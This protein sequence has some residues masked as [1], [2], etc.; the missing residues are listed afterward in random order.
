MKKLFPILLTLAS[1]IVFFACTKVQ[2]LPYYPE[3]TAVTLTANK[4][5]VTATAADSNNNVLTFNWS[6]PKYSSDSSTWKY[7]LEIDSTGKNFANKTTRTFTGTSSGSLT[8]KDLNDIMLNYGYSIGSAVGMDFRVV[9]SYGNNNERYVSNTVKVLV[10]P[11]NDPAVLTSEK[12]SVTGTLATAGNPS[13]TFSW[14]TAFRG[15]TGTVTYSLQY[16]SATKNFASP[17]EMAVGASIYSKTLT[18]AEMNQAALNEG[19]AGGT[20]GKIEFRIKAT[21]AQGAVSYSA[22]VSVTIGAYVPAYNFYLVGDFNGWDINTAPELIS[23]RAG[24]RW[25]KVF[26]SYVYMTAGQKF[27]FVKTRGDWGSKYGYTGGGA[28]GIY[29]IGAMG[30]GSDFQV[31]TTGVYRI[32]IDFNAN[33]AYVQ[34]KQVGVVGGMQGWNPGS[35][36]YGGLLAKDKFLIIAPSSGSDNFK[37]H[38][39]PVWD[40]SAPDKAR[41]WGRGASAGLLDNDGNGPD[42]TASF[43]PYTRAIWDGTDP[44]QLKYSLSNGQLRVV[45]GAASLG[46]WDPSAAPNMN[47]MGNGVWQATITLTGNTEF[48]FVSAEGWSY[49]YGGSG[50]SGNAGTI[51]LNGPNLNKPAGTYT[52]TVNE[53]TQ[54]YT[55]I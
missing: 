47:Y 2:D 24:S 54:T 30:T 25:G 34:Q 10:T 55:I 31:S 16:D 11:Y 42:I 36:I 50:G 12:T 29:D 23:D 4:T 8:G 5:S 22:P 19:V 13:N 9:S 3:G 37:F 52:I 33:K 1:G 14:T 27:L 44:Q 35:P 32:T 7:I 6:S 53:Y 39:G 20:T 49:N 15:Y 26:Y 17:Q 28:S 40:N 43:A 45:G 46:N 41:W 51:S 21:T 18:V 48:K 38:D